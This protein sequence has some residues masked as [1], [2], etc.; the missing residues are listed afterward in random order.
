MFLGSTVAFRPWIQGPRVRYPAG[1]SHFRT[2]F[3]QRVCIATV[4]LS[5][6]FKKDPWP[7]QER[8]QIH[9][10]REVT[11]YEFL[12]TWP[13]TKTTNHMPEV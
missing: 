9:Y 7:I 8:K 10:H 5:Y 6:R 4:G 13:T 3:L 12:P 11:N 1:A 2:A